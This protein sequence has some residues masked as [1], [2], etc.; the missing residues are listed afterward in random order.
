[1]KLPRRQTT[2]QAPAADLIFRR[3]RRKNESRLDEQ[4]LRHRV[5]EN[6]NPDR[7]L[8]FSNKC[9][10]AR[11]EELRA[12][13]ARH[14]LHGWAIFKIRN[15]D[16][17]A[18]GNVVGTEEKAKAIVSNWLRIDHER[19]VA[20]ASR[21]IDKANRLAEVTGRDQMGKS[22]EVK[23]FSE[24]SDVEITISKADLVAACRSIRNL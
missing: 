22:K 15:G 9:T 23:Q 7:V 13:R 16:K 20:A 6:H 19:A 12:E 11:R 2:I 8:R 14:P 18:T 1:M 4:T 3:R 24:D 21:A 17:V 5:T 10:P